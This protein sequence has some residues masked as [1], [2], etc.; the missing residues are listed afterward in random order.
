MLALASVGLCFG[1]CWGVQLNGTPESTA[2]RSSFLFQHSCNDMAGKI[3]KSAERNSQR[4]ILRNFKDGLIYLE[5]DLFRHKSLFSSKDW[6][7]LIALTG[8]ADKDFEKARKS[9]GE[10]IAQGYVPPQNFDRLL[11]PL[12]GDVKLLID[13]LRM[14]K[15]TGG[16]IREED[17]SPDPSKCAND[18]Y[19]EC[20]YNSL[21][22]KVC[23]F[24]CYHCCGQGGCK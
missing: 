7:I 6:L 18:C 21:G 20:G 22:E 5:M 24:T 19:R 17:Y 11:S 23:W 15:F 8:K 16:G 4:S 2:L 14:S 3:S 1:T 13:R 10:K 12:S 9:Y